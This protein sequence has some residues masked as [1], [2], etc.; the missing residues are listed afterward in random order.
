MY[1]RNLHLELSS[2]NHVAEGAEIVELAL[3]VMEAGQT[4]MTTTETACQPDI[5]KSGDCNN[6]HRQPTNKAGAKTS[7]PES[8][9]WNTAQLKHKGPSDKKGSPCKQ[10][11]TPKLSPKEQDKSLAEGRCFCCKGMGHKS[12]D[13]SEGET[14]H[15]NAASTIR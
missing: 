1:L 9:L 2:L 11:L 13:C 3:S 8:V 15:V 7:Q 12:K 6:K 14:V 5:G 4:M 10:M